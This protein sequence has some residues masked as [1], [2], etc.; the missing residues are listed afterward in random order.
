MARKKNRSL[1]SKRELFR[2]KKVHG[3][4][5]WTNQLLQKLSVDNEEAPT[6]NAN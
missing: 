3:G 2:Q 4:T 6:K 5:R 1:R